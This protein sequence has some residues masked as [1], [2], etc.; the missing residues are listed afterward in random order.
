MNPSTG[1]CHTLLHFLQISEHTPQLP[2]GT[3][4]A[5]IQVNSHPSEHEGTDCP[6]VRDVHHH[7]KQ[8]DT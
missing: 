8:Q 1:F 3:V 2:A 4:H 6:A 7:L 5:F